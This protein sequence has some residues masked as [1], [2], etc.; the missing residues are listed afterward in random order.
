[1]GANFSTSNANKD[2]TPLM[3]AVEADDQALV[4]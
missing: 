1:M 3:S 2:K 4:Q